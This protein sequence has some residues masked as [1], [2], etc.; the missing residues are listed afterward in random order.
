M[1]HDPDTINSDISETSLAECQVIGN[2]IMFVGPARPWMVFS[3]QGLNFAHPTSQ[4]RYYTCGTKNQPLIS[5]A[6]SE[7]R[8]RCLVPSDLA[9]NEHM[10]K[11]DPESMRFL[12]CCLYLL[13]IHRSLAKGLTLSLSDL[14]RNTTF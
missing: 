9:C 5:A 6:R 8:Q 1:T 14:V 10:A 4:L 12:V 2:P 7:Q 13:A 11:M 3:I